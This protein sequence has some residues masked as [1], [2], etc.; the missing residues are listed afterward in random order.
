[1]RCPNVCA[2]VSDAVQRDILAAAGRT[3]QELIQYAAADDEDG[4]HAVSRKTLPHWLA[5]PHWRANS[6]AKAKVDAS[7]KAAAVAAGDAK[8]KPTASA[9]S[10]RTLSA[11]TRGSAVAG[12]AAS[13]AVNKE[14]A[15]ETINYPVTPASASITVMAVENL[16]HNALAAAANACEPDKKDEVFHDAIA[17]SALAVDAGDVAGPPLPVRV[18][19]STLMPAQ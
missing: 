9:L 18:Q 10:G 17:T 13:D 16:A 12:D 1:V 5:Q 7:A 6:S 15:L 14:P 2:I 11:A 4:P 19:A 8:P 3:P